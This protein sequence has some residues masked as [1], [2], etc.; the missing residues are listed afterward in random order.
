LAPKLVPEFFTKVNLQ[1]DLRI[2][3]ADLSVF[4]SQWLQCTHPGDPC[5]E[6]PDTPWAYRPVTVVWR[7]FIA[8]DVNQDRYV[9]L[10]D[11]AMILEQWLTQD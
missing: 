11:L 7:D 1:R 9:D 3:L 5:I 2:D 6:S 4:A 8:A 10:D